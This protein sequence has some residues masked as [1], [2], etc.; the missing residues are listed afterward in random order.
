MEKRKF[1]I[2][3]LDF[4]IFVVI[5]CSVAVLVFR[6]T[7]NEVFTTPEVTTLEVVFFIDGEDKC[8]IIRESLNTDVVFISDVKND[9]QTNAKLAHFKAALGSLTVPQ[10]GD[11]SIKISGYKRLGRFYTED[12][13][14]IRTDSECAIIIGEERID[15]ELLSVNICG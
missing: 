15:G 8:D 4:V 14:R 5:L 12:G 2:N 10:K 1:K 13:T 7:V 11:V 9:I 3:I 6:D